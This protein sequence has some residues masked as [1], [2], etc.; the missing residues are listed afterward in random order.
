MKTYSIS[1]LNENSKGDVGIRFAPDVVLKK[2]KENFSDVI[3]D[4]K[5]KVTKRIEGIK[6]LLSSSEIELQ[7]KAYRAMIAE[8]ELKRPDVYLYH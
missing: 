7:R 4:D 1:A 2:I 8:Y 6:K 3:I 5:D